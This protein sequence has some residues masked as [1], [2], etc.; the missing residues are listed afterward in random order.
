MK[1]V[2]T[3][4]GLLCLLLVGFWLLLPH[5]VSAQRYNVAYNNTGIEQVMNDLRK[6]T[7]YEFV[8]QKQII[9]D[10]KP[11][12]CRMENSSLNELLDRIFAD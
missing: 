1:K 6:K 12:T 7:G 3:P 5:S 11:I 10:V 9:R 2:I 4:K 8:Y